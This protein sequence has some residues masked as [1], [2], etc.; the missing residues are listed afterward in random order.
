MADLIFLMG[1]SSK[2]DLDILR[3]MGSWWGS[4]SLF[5]D[6]SGEASLLSAVKQKFCIREQVLLL[7]SYLLAKEETSRKCDCREVQLTTARIIWYFRNQDS[8]P[9]WST[10][11][12]FGRAGPHGAFLVCHGGLEENSHKQCTR[13]KAGS[14]SK[15][16]PWISFP[17]RA[18]LHL[19]FSC[20]KHS[21]FLIRC[22]ELSY[23][24][25]H[26]P[27]LLSYPLLAGGGALCS[28]GSILELSLKLYC[29]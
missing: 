14:M 16:L 10:E 29:F 27:G 1:N 15:L 6:C 23:W 28:T 17:S 22:L 18:V 4:K 26:I 2:V 7:I 24:F 19:L 11:S 12:F 13:W 8:P 5:N 9:S 3:C 20:A 25:E 21:V